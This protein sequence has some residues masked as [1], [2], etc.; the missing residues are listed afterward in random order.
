MPAM[1]DASDPR[2]Y[3]AHVARNRQSIV[4]VLARVLPPSGLVLETLA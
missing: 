4:D 2:L 1:D 3:H